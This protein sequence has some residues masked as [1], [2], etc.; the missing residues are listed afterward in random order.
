M[1]QQQQQ[2]RDVGEAADLHDA[3][4]PRPSGLVI[5]SDAGAAGISSHFVIQVSVIHCHHEHG[6]GHRHVHV[7]SP[8]QGHHSFFLRQRTCSGSRNG[9][10][11]EEVA[12]SGEPDSSS[13]SSSNLSALAC[14][15]AAL[16]ARGNAVA[17][18]L[19]TYTESRLVTRG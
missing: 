16:R 10:G 14:Y 15:G 17:R 8:R 2:E 6:D 9:K 19:T 12:F 5:D 13:S 1:V 4:H 3:V 7:G 18:A 11:G